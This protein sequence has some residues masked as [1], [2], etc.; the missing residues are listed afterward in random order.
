MKLKLLDQT[1]YSIIKFPNH[2]PLPNEFYTINDFKSVTYTAEEC[3]VIVPENTIDTSEALA[4]NKDWCIIQIVG[5]LDFSL[6]GIL[7]QLANPLAENNISIFAV[8]TYMTD[9]LLI[10]NQDKLNALTVLKKAG[11]SF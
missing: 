6:V 8:S 4:V 9:F 10:K 5:E 3:S 1:N 11:H 2:L 7:T